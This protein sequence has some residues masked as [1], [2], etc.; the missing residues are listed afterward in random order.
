M[1]TDKENLDSSFDEDHVFHSL[2]QQLFLLFH[3]P[4]LARYLWTQHFYWR[5]IELLPLKLLQLLLLPH[6]SPSRMWLLMFLPLQSL[7]LPLLLPGQMT[8]HLF[9]P[10]YF[11]LFSSVPCR[12]CFSLDGLLDP[13]IQI[14]TL[15]ATGIRC[16]IKVRMVI[17]AQ[18]FLISWT[19]ACCAFAWK[20][21][22]PVQF[23]FLLLLLL[24]LIS[25]SSSHQIFCGP[26]P[27]LY[28][29]IAKI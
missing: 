17:L 10:L 19:Q 8:Y 15:V 12:V 3:L 9:L 28:A 4:F 7:L 2:L 26:D 18:L 25:G 27:R 29:R 11:A 22:V 24:L 14:V 23:S 5:E 16:T 20:S 1:S 13:S 6:L 21:P